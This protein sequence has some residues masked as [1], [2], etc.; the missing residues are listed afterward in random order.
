M[1]K[2]LTR[3]R[4]ENIGDGKHRLIE[5][6]LYSSD[7]LG[8]IEVPAGFVTDFASVPRLPLVYLLFGGIGDEEAVLHDWLYTSPH[9]VHT[10]CGR[11]VTRCEA[12]RLF[13]GARYASAYT[14]LTSYESVNVTRLAKNTWAYLGAWCMWVGVRVFGWRHWD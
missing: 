9:V 2:Y 5:P 11:L 14:P 3:L 8:L 13:R 12:D 6:F 7:T 1:G 4:T 10:G